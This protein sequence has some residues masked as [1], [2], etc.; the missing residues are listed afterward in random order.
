MKSIIECYF[1]GCSLFSNFDFSVTHKK[2]RTL[3][4]QKKM[5]SIFFTSG[6]SL[7]IFKCDIFH[8]SVGVFMG[9]N[10]LLKICFYKLY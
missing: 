4:A 7:N 8:H 5:Y 9:Y 10:L 1:V 2:V 3:A 6:N